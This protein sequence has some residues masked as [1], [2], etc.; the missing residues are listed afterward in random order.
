MKSIYMRMDEW[1][2][3]ALS[4]LRIVA[5]LLFL[6]HGLRSYL[7]FR[8]PDRPSTVFYSRQR[9]WKAS[10]HCCCLQALTPELW[11]LSS[12]ARWPL[13][14]SWRM[15]RGLS[16]QSPMAEKER[17][18]SALYFSTSPSRVAAPGASTDS[19]DRISPPINHV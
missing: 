2:P 19:A 3:H 8:F 1:R 4:V 5:A 14:I 18:S 10:V 7:A 16:I 11:R 9:S 12:P 17:S 13:P 15:R 6:Q